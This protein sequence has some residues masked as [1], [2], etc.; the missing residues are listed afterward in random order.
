MRASAE[1]E[2]KPLNIA[3]MIVDM[4][5][6]L[7]CATFPCPS[8][9]VHISLTVPETSETLNQPGEILAQADLTTGHWGFLERL[10]WNL[11][12]TAFDMSRLA[13]CSI[14]KEE[15]RLKEAFYDCLHTYETAR[16]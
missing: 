15:N 3:G 2:K 8:G 6:T 9:R 4:I 12:Q 13:R 11:W 7:E 16:N 1:G 5:V 14:E 10:S